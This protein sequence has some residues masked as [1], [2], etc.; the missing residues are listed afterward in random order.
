M[1][2]PEAA[3]KKD[4]F[5]PAWKSQ[6]RFAGQVLSVQPVAVAHSVNNAPNG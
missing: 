5:F 6:I 1:V 3:V 2:V 4:H